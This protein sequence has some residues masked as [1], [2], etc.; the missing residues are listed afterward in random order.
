MV[1]VQPGKM[2][3]N[4]SS[5][6]R[7]HPRHSLSGGKLVKTASSSALLVSPRNTISTMKMFAWNARPCSPMCAS[8]KARYWQS[9]RRRRASLQKAHAMSGGS[10]ANSVSE[11]TTRFQSF[12]SVFF[13]RVRADSCAMEQPEKPRSHGV[14]GELDNTRAQPC[15]SSGLIGYAVNSVDGPLGRYHC[16]AGAQYFGPLTCSFGPHSRSVV[17]RRSPRVTWSSFE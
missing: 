3:V 14:P 16:V 2:G 17:A 4:F 5:T 1:L 15:L 11:G 13:P 7:P 10:H 12:F 6:R 8:W 9:L